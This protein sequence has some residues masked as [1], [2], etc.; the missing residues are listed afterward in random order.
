[1]KALIID[2]EKH[3]RDA[4]RLLIDWNRYGISS[5][6]EAKDGEE[7]TQMIQIHRPEIIFTDMMMPEMNGSELIEWAA[8]HSPA[9]KLIVVSGH[10]DF[11]LVRHT[12]KYGGLDYILKPIDP[13]QLDA[14]LSRAVECWN[15]EERD[16]SRSRLQAIELNQLKPMFLEHYFCSILNEPSAQQEMPEAIMRELQLEAPIRRVR[17]AVASLELSAPSIR[18]KFATSGPDLM[19]F[20]LTNICN[21]ILMA[22]GAGCAFRYWGTEQELVL[23]FWEGA[24]QAREQ[25]A[26]INGAIEEALKIRFVFGLGAPSSFPSGAA[27]SYEGAKTALLRRNVLDSRS[28]EVLEH[29]AQTKRGHTLLAFHEFEEQIRFAVQS[30]GAE[31]IRRAL[32]DWF[33]FIEKSGYVSFE[34]LIHWHQHFELTKAIWELPD[35]EEEHGASERSE[36]RNERRQERREGGTRSIS[37]IPMDGDGNFR[38]EAWKE[39]VFADVCALSQRILAQSKD[40]GVIHEIAKYIE[41]NAGRDI[42]LQ[43]VASHFYLSREYI[44]RKFKQEMNEN[45]SDYIAGIRMNRAKEL[46]ANKGLKISQIAE[47][48]GFH[49]E[50]YF[51]KVFKKWIGCT[52]NDYRK[53]HYG[54]N[55]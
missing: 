39:A 11:S 26:A 44:S 6:Y 20:A 15:R 9:S 8:R 34:A 14:A 30:G 5:L 48:V 31:R 45:I 52:P 28:G 18:K 32:N 50:K 27:F 21:E 42:T 25:L 1:M 36:E 10:D 33:S 55:G 13:E 2:D 24:E 35:Q 46:L 23:I 17:I 51:S 41:Q 47:Q 29:D 16:R 40:K 4:I 3:V 37:D 49:D 53:H 12:L 43:D 22:E 54:N 19:F 7:A 38:F